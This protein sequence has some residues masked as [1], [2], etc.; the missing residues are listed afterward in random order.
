[1]SERLEA[2]PG[3]RLR[4]LREARGI[5][6][7]ELEKQTGIKRTTLYSYEGRGYN[8]RGENLQILT[9]FYGVTAGYLLGLEAGE[10]APDPESAS[11]MSGAKLSKV[12]HLLASPDL[13][14]LVHLENACKAASLSQAETDVAVSALIAHLLYK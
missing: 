14:K 5:G 10:P 2:K 4:Q 8:P 3:N 12:A 13:L 11:L 9:K 6:V 1:M 7:S